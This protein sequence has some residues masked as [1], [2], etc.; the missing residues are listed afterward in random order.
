VVSRYMGV[1]ID[2]LEQA[3]LANTKKFFNI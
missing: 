1:D 3:V 2:V